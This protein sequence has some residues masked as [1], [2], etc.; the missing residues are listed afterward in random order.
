MLKVGYKTA[1]F[2]LTNERLVQPL[3]TYLCHAC[4]LHLS[5]AQ[6]DYSCYITVLHT[7][8]GP[9]LPDFDSYGFVVPHLI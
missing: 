5:F 8:V 3:W 4:P 7:S 6:R 9:V 1:H 2:P